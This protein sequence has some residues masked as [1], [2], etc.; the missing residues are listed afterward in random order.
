MPA[1]YT[2]IAIKELWEKPRLTVV[3]CNYHMKAA[4]LYNSDDK[5]QVETY[6][7][8]AEALGV[9]DFG[10]YYDT[11]EKYLSVCYEL[12]GMTITPN[13]KAEEIITFLALKALA[14]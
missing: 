10:I 3:R 8:Y 1:K 2:L 14:R 13:T 12:R 7:F 9:K 11:I 4:P 6:V 5:I